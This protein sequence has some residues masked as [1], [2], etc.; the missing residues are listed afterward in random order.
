MGRTWEKTDSPDE[1]KKKK[2][3]KACS[4]QELSV[5]NEAKRGEGELV[6]PGGYGAAEVPRC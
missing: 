4:L 2:M 6:H 1:G 5:L 3:R